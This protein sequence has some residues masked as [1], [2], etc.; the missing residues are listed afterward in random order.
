MDEKYTSF[1]TRMQKAIAFFLEEFA[2]VRAGK[3]NAAVLDKVTVDYYGTQTPIQQVG[4]IS[5]PEPRMLVIQPWDASLVKEIEKAILKSEVGITP[6]N[7]GK[8]IRLVFPSLTEERR[9]ELVKVVNKKAEE[10][11]VSVRAVRRDAMDHF[12]KL[13]KSSEI[14]ED[15]LKNIEKDIQNFT[16]KYI[17][18]IDEKT[19]IKEKEIIEI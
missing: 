7:D 4:T 1:E 11:K 19:K 10:A 15:D 8:T 14:T 9:K 18:E 2:T 5:V 16:D 6:T 13:Q 3:A 17:K 12:K